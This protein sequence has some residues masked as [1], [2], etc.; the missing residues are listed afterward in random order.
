MFRM[1]YGTNSESESF[2]QFEGFSRKSPM[3]S[4][5]MFYADKGMTYS[6]YLKNLEKYYNRQVRYQKFKAFFTKLFS[7]I[8]SIY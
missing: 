7:K 6:T 5:Y 8:I 4:N 1:K 2:S 3:V